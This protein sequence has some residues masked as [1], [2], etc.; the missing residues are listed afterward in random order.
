MKA[1][2]HADKHYTQ[3]S[4]FTATAGTK[5]SQTVIYAVEGTTADA[6]NEVVEGAVVKAVYIE[7]WTMSDAVDGSQIIVVCKDTKDGT[8]PTYAQCVALNTYTNK[9][10]ILHTQ[11]GLAPQEGAGSSPMPA[12]K[13]WIKIPKGKQRFGLGDTLI[14]TIANP[15]ANNLHCCGFATYKEYT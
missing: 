14:L 12:F 3:W 11:Q 5:A 6:N 8:G 7:L 13:G 15:S 2:I 1:P 4:L 10:N 9:K